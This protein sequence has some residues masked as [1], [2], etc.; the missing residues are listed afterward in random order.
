M[1]TQ[2]PPTIPDRDALRVLYDQAVTEINATRPNVNLTTGFYAETADS[3][4]KASY[5][6]LCDHCEGPV[7]PKRVH[8]VSAPAGGGKTSFSYAFMA[9]LTRYAETTPDAPSSCVF[10]V[11]QIKKADEAYQDLNALMPGKVAVW[12]VEHDRRCKPKNRTRVP[13]PAAE[14]TV[15]ELRRYPVIVVTHAFYNGRKGSKATF[16]PD[17]YNHERAL[18]VVDE[19]PEEVEIYE[20]TLKDAQAV[21]EKLEAKRPDLAEVL[22]KLLLFI[23]PFSFSNRDNAIVRG[24]DVF[25]QD[26]IAAE[27]N[28]FATDDGI[29]PANVEIGR[30]ALLALSR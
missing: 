21:R 2:V 19:R 23:M 4:F 10:V 15:D 29:A 7:G 24:A 17:G 13:N 28:W 6:A 16:I 3:V 9:A 30:A 20:T 18:A 5:L 25:G 22:D 27:L 12:T 11:D 14:F 8:V 26:F 1:T